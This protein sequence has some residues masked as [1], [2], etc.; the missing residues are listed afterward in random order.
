METAFEGAG[1]AHLHRFCQSLTA[2]ERLSFMK[3]SWPDYWL[4]TSPECVE[5]IE[6]LCAGP[7]LKHIHGC[8]AVPIDFWCFNP[9]VITINIPTFEGLTE[10]VDTVSGG[11][12]EQYA[13]LQSLTTRIEMWPI[14]PLLNRH[15]DLFRGIREV[16][17]DC[18]TAESLDSVQHLLDLTANTV[19][20]IDI[21]ICSTW[22]PSK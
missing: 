17:I 2:I 10:D 16:K 5:A 4:A 8:V 6:I 3:H 22:I 12:P 14:E 1:K 15:P 13:P 9:N 21:R 7:R 11:A 19:S 20:D 18:V